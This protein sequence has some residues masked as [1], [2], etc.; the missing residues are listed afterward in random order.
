MFVRSFKKIKAAAGN[1]K[2]RGV[3]LCRGISVLLSHGIS[4]LLSHGII[5]FCS[6]ILYFGEGI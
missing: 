5:C 1:L 2:K 6:R 3:L 4:V